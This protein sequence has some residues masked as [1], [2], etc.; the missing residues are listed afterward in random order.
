MIASIIL[1]FF[2]SFIVTALITPPAISLL[3]KHKVIDDP[4]RKHPG[5]IHKKPIPRGGGIPLF[6][7]VVVASLIFIPINPTTIAIFVASFISLVIGV[8][9][10]KIDISPYFRFIVQIACAII[11]VASGVNIPFITNPFGGIL[12]L[13]HFNLPISL[14]GMHV[15][16]SL[17]DFIA[18]F[19][20]VWVMNMLNWS[21]GVDGQMPGIEAICVSLQLMRQVF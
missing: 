18:I 8:L 3:K 2:I 1:S 12:Y 19:W 20:I 7:G 10:D 13:N 17:S 9:D 11:I 6:L 21:K 5:V 15:V 4:K 16:F 14:L